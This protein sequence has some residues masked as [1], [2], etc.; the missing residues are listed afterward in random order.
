MYEKKPVYKTI[1]NR[2]LLNYLTLFVTINIYRYMFL[3]EKNVCRWVCVCVCR[4][5]YIWLGEYICI[6]MYKYFV[7]SNPGWGLSWSWSSPVCHGIFF[8]QFFFFLFMHSFHHAIKIW[9]HLSLVSGKSNFSL[10]ISFF[11]HMPCTNSSKNRNCSFEFHNW[12]I[13]WLGFSIV[14]LQQMM[15]FRFFSSFPAK[16]KRKYI[17]Y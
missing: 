16:Q 5:V 12:T 17:S 10:Q 13:W 11:C 1:K 6:Y 14:Q 2:N 7:T 4:W 9:Q 15:M 3:K 8:F